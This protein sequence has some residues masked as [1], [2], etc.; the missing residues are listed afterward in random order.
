MRSCVGVLYFSFFNDTME[1]KIYAYSYEYLK[2]VHRAVCLYVDIWDAEKG[3]GE[4]P[5]K[6]MVVV[7]RG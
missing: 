6:F 3:E 4:G 5:L 1:M 2:S 7:G